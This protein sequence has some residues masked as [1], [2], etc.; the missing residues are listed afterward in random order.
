MKDLD[1]E[2]EDENNQLNNYSTDDLFKMRREQETSLKHKAAQYTGKLRKRSPLPVKV[3]DESLED[4]DP[5]I[6]YDQNSRRAFYRNRSIR[7]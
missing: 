1:S 3:M 6:R 7:H 4:L 2:S 5:V